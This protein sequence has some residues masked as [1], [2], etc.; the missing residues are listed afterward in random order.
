MQISVTH[1]FQGYFSRTF[2][3]KVVFQDFPGP[4]ILKKKIQD[5]P[6]GVGTLLLATVTAIAPEGRNGELCATV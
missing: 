6:G 1:N 2:R 3:T 4:G 5:F